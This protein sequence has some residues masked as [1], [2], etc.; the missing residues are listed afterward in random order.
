MSQT[1]ASTVDRRADGPRVRPLTGAEFLES[2]HDGREVWIRGERVKEVTTHPAFRN[3]ARMLARMYDALYDPGRKS[4]LTADTDTGNG[5][6]TH[7]FF[8]VHCHRA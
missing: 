7:K 8:K 4:V 3:S 6:F 2:L 5:G 1:T